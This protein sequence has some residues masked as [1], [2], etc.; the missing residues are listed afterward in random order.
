MW[1]KG[2]TRADN[3]A[4]AE[5]RNMVGEYAAVMHKMGVR[6]ATEGKKVRGLG[7]YVYPKD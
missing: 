4:T 7:V 1:Q 3:E 6:F 5:D 2:L